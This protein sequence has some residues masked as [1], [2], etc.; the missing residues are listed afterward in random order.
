MAWAVI[1]LL[2]AIQLM[3]TEVI[4]PDFYNAAQIVGIPLVR[5]VSGLAGIYFIILPLYPR[6]N[7]WQRIQKI[8][9]FIFSG[10]T[11]ALIYIFFSVL[12]I[13]S[14]FLKPSLSLIW[15][16]MQEDFISNLH[17][18]AAYYF[19]VLTLLLAMDYFEDK[20][21]A[22]I[23]KEKAE[24]ELSLA[25]FSILKNQLQPHFL[26]NA[27]NSIVSI[28]DDRKEA[29]QDMLTDVS[30]LLRLSLDTDYS[31]LITVEEEIQILK[32][33]LNIEKRRFEH[34]L[35]IIEKYEENILN[36]QIPPFT[37]QPLVE[38]AIKH[39]FGEGIKQLLIQILISRSDTELIIKIS[40]NGM[41]LKDAALGTG[42]QN[43]QKRLENAFRGECEFK[44]IQ[45]DNWVLSLIKIKLP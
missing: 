12:L 39:G 16:G 22:E 34:Q 45:D 7:K 37:L 9:G 3:I 20:G 31:E 41:P 10:L 40:N 11:F 15:A 26:F 38:N 28:I 23:I 6:I 4:R 30:D 1:N 36:H 21:R 42:L 14:L 44:L 24:K 2:L 18:I 43:L 27:L 29:A 32:T 5:F 35:E 8:C 25:Q 17:F 19:F 13:Q 33:Y